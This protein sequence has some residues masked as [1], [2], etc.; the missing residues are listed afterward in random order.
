MK[1]IKILNLKLKKIILVDYIAASQVILLAL[2]VLITFNL[3]P[4]VEND[5]YRYFEMANDYSGKQFI[6][7]MKETTLDFKVA[8]ALFWFSGKINCL[9]LIPAT[10]VFIVYGITFWIINDAGKTLEIKSEI[11]HYLLLS[12]ALMQFDVIAS[13]VRNVTAFAVSALAAYRDLFKNKKNVIT[14]IL[15]LLPCGLHITAV[16]FLLAR[17]LLPIYKK[18][19]LLCISF[20]ILT[21]T[22][23]KTLFFYNYIFEKIPFV[24]ETIKKAHYYFFAFGETEW[25]GMVKDSG[26]E[27][28]RKAVFFIVIIIFFLLTIFVLK[29]IKS[30]MPQ[31][32]NIVLYTEISVLLTIVSMYIP[33]PTYFRFSVV[34]F[35]LCSST[36]FLAIKYRIQ[37]H[38]LI[39][40]LYA[41]YICLVLYG[42]AA[43]VYHFYFN[44]RL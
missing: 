41:V 24:R 23:I 8:A 37:K 19:H 7:V 39:P 10:T 15:Y 35:S 18:F 29:K 22:L 11:L 25:A 16:I 21:P 36:F 31:Y 20:V 17:I 1:T 27:Q 40:I 6:T 4:I 30:V 43:Q 2:F 44:F 34:M 32:I 26:F 33:V 28:I 12:L 14:V 13:N 38:G 9:G 5:L 42:L 3:K